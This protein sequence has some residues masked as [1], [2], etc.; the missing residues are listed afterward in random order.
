MYC[1][2]SYDPTIVLEAVASQD[3]WIWHYFFGLSGTLNDINVLQRSHLFKKLIA[4]DA[5]MCNY[6]IMGHEYSIGYYIADGIYP[7]WATFVK[8]IKDPPTDAERIFAKAQEAARKDIERAFGVLQARFAIVRG[9]A[10][11]WDKETLINIMTY[12]VILH[13]M[14]IEDER[15]LKLTCFYDNV[16]TRVRPER[17]PNRLEGFLQTYREI[18][19]KATHK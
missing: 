1:G 14:I 3:L 13:N 18:E 19:D 17:N 6:K 15:G 12:C 10:R 4:G 5:P 9:P 8:S 16:D 7:E 2:K 11:F